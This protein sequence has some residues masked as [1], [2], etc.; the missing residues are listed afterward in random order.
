LFFCLNIHLEEH[1]KSTHV[2]GKSSLEFGVVPPYSVP[3]DDSD[4][5]GFSRRAPC[6]L[7]ESRSGCSQWNKAS[8][9][10]YFKG[11]KTIEHS[12]QASTAIEQPA[13][14]IQLFY[15]AAERM[16]PQLD[17]RLNVAMQRKLESKAL[18]DNLYCFPADLVA[19]LEKSPAQTLMRL[20]LSIR[21]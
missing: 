14:G 13:A 7:A 15:A 4:Q 1:L 16:V 17:R 6:T 20:I 3:F 19:Y 11:W 18:S 2:A 12:I 5:T 10:E 21:R 8:D 9:R